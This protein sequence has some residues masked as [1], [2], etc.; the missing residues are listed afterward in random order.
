M[1]FFPTPRII[2]SCL[3]LIENFNVHTFL[4][5]FIKVFNK[6]CRKRA[7]YFISE[8]KR[9]GVFNHSLTV[10]QRL[11]LKKSFHHW[12]AVTSETGHAI[13]MP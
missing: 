11:T 8:E 9:T 6:T 4:L 2:I 12:R 13:D 3:F 5:I 10:F 1:H 7:F